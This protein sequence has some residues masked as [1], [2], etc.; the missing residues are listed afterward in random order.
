MD[1]NELRK[2]C[3]SE[4]SK[5]SCEELDSKIFENVISLD[6]FKSA[7][8]VLCYVSYKSEVDTLK[9]ISYCLENNKQTAV[10]Y[11]DDKY[12]KMSF[13]VIGS[14]DV[15]KKGAFGILEPDNI[16]CRKLTDFSSAIIIVPGLCFSEKGYRLGYGKGYYDRFLK[17]KSFISVGLCYNS[18]IKKEIP[19]NDY[20]EAVDI[21][22]SDK[23]VIRINNGGKNG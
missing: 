12:G 11:C 4:R 1:K 23:E 13:Y 17:N 22:V 3:N 8:T 2:L 9:L 5:V 7:E 18:L 20:D 10:P 19:I 14:L 6:E 15:L 21:I 16:K